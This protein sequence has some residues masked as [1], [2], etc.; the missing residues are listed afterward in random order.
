V[1]PLQTPV[2]SALQV[3][4]LPHKE[5]HNALGVL[6]EHTQQPLLQPLL[7]CA[8]HVKLIDTPLALDFQAV[9]HASQIIMHL[10][11]AALCVWLLLVA[12]L[13]IMHH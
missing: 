8:F 9:S 1:L 5:Q 13:A 3:N 4:I 7:L 2:C 11:W 10:A 6:L 12:V